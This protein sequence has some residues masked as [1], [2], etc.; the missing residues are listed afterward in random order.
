MEAA[1]PVFPAKPYQLQ[2]GLMLM[3]PHDMHHLCV[4]MA[5]QITMA[6]TEE[7]FSGIPPGP[8]DRV[9]LNDVRDIIGSEMAINPSE[10]EPEYFPDHDGFLEGQR[11][12]MNG[13]VSRKGPKGT[14]PVRCA[15]LLRYMPLDNG[16]FPKAW[17]GPIT[18]VSGVYKVN[19]WA[20]PNP[21]EMLSPSRCM[22]F[23]VS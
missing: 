21:I 22:T 17:P 7:L 20:L 18:M 8:F 1:A 12:M 4:L 15:E 23:K 9:H 11:S 6:P 13:R 19:Y 2:G 10:A 5:E 16:G 3:H 14:A